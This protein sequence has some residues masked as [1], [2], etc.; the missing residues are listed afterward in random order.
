MA[1]LTT[2][3]NISFPYRD[4][5][6]DVHQIE[7]YS[8]LPT[9]EKLKNTFLFGIPLLSNLNGQTMSDEAIAYF[10]Q[11]SISE[12][13]HMLD[14]YITPIEVTE[15]MDYNKELWM[16]SFAYIKVN[17]P[18][19]IDVSKVELAFIGQ[20]QSE[21]GW[22]TF[23]LEYVHVNPQEGTIQL[24]PSLSGGTFGGFMATAVPGAVM[25]SLNSMA[26]TNYPGIVRIKY[27]CG[28]EIDKIPA[29]INELI[30]I[31]ASLSILGIIGPL[32]FPYSSVSVGIDGISQSTGGLGPNF[33]NRRID[34]LNKRKAELIDSIKGYYSRKFLIDSF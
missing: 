3:K 33:F 4:S 22:I 2:E 19:I 11:G 18:N 21:P 7:R 17:H 6:S 20:N 13:E 27:R 1:R 31:I 10:I 26:V 23:P 9:P 5:L 24:V 14:L 28:F 32:L 15:K 25:W 16:L 29:A 30:S 12:I 8:P 34:D